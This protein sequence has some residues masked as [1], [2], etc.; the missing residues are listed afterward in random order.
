M[1]L[2]YNKCDRTVKGLRSGFTWSVLP[3]IDVLM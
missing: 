3:D 1:G 2:V